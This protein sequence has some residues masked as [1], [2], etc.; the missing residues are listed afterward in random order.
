MNCDQKNRIKN[1]LPSF[2][3]VFKTKTMQLMEKKIDKTSN[4]TLSPLYV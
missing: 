3:G 2:Y 1:A 4:H